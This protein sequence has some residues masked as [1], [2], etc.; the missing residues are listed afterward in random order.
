LLSTKPY[1]VAQFQCHHTAEKRRRIT[2]KQ[3]QDFFFS[4][5][6]HSALQWMTSGSTALPRPKPNGGMTIRNKLRT[7]NT[8]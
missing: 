6:Q 8:G 7:G 4:P 3:L 1:L 5:I 2:T